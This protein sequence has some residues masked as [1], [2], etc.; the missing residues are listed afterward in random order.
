MMGEIF[1]SL[2]ADKPARVIEAFTGSRMHNG[3]TLL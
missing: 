3:E 1:W 2:S